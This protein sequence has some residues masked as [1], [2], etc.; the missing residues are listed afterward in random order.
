M[1]K[2]LADKIRE[3]REKKGLSQSKLA[4]LSGISLRAVQNYE[5]GRVPKS[6]EMYRRLA[7]GLGIDLGDL[8]DEK[9]QFV[10]LAKEKFGSTGADQARK[11][12]EQ[13]RVLMAGGQLK[14]DDL[15]AISTAVMES[16]WK[17]K[18][19]NKRRQP[20]GERSGGAADGE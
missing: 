9:E 19:M 2:S 11:C 1:C 14:D 5:A 17:A 8:I 15:D 4:T 7:V 12:V 16:Y 20:S 18:E 3:E 10:L 6:L 13:L